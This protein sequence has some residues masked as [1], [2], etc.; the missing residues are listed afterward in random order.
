[1]VRRRANKAIGDQ[2]DEREGQRAGHERNLDSA[3]RRRVSQSDR[4][5]AYCDE[6]TILAALIFLSVRTARHVR[7]HSGHIAHLTDRQAFCRRGRYQRRS[8]QANDHK[9][10]KQTTDESVK[11]HDLSSHGMGN[12]GRLFPSQVRQIANRACLKYRKR[13]WLAYR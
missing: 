12:L 11:I 8:N 6:R 5:H 1:M 9:D 7:R 2:V 3:C 4:Q 10:R 13:R